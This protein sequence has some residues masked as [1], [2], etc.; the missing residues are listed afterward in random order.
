MQIDLGMVYE[1]D[2][3][4]I[5]MPDDVWRLG[6]DTV[7]GRRRIDALA[8]ASPAVIANQFVPGGR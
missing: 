5:N 1:L 2:N 8:G 3:R 6:S 7:F 4:R